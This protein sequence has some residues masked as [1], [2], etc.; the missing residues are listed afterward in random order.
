MDLVYWVYVNVLVDMEVMIVLHWCARMIAME[1]E[2]VV[3]IAINMSV[4]Q[5]VNAI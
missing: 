5:F 3:L 4:H 2:F 1:M